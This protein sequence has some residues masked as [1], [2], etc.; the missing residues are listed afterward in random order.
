MAALLMLLTAVDLGLGGL[1]FGIPP[2]KIPVFR[3]AFGVPDELHPPTYDAF[4]AYMDA[5]IAGLD[6]T[7]ECRDVARTVLTPPTPAVV[8][9]A[10]LLG[11]LASV[12][13]LPPRIREGLRLRWNRGTEAAFRAMAASL[14]GIVPLVPARVRY[15]P[16]ARL[17]DRRMQAG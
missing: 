3:S 7:D 2:R 13:L 10:G 1:F 16:H 8:M 14:R 4:V 12:G 6:I 15:W 11:G 17:A 5:T 9:P